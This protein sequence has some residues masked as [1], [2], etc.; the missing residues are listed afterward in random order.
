MGVR[1]SGCPARRSPLF[2]LKE[3]ELLTLYKVPQSRGIVHDA[4]GPGIAA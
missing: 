1:L 3:R 2:H 4:D